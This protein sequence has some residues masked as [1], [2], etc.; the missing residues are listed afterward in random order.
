MKIF[1]GPVIFPMLNWLRPRKIVEVGALYGENTVHL[2]QYCVAANAKLFCI[3]PA[4]A[5]DVAAFSVMYRRHFQMLQ[6]YSLQALPQL[7]DYDFVLL[8]GDHNWYTVYNELKIIER[9]A[10]RRGLF[11]AVLLHDIEW[12]YGR[13]DMYYFPGTI[14]ETFRHP[15][16]RKGVVPGRSGLADGGLNEGSAHAVHEGGAR[17]G[18]LTAVE[19]FLK[20]TKFNLL[21]YKVVPHHGLGIL[22]PNLA[23]Y[24]LALQGLLTASGLEFRRG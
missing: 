1:W 12:P 16:E 8:D 14:P 9:M 21:F 18:V 2:L 24:E 5:F 19:D 23:G 10:A 15:F 7:R 17:N 11:P 4:P 3:D 22:I 20:E 13:R 6:N